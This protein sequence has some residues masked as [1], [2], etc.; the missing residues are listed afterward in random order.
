MR[1]YAMK[2]PD[3]MNRPDALECQH[4]RVGEFMENAVALTTA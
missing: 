3:P 4:R 2:P 1:L